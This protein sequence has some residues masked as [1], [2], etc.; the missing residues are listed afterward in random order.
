MAILFVLGSCLFYLHVDG[1]VLR[2][3]EEGLFRVQVEEV[4][5]VELHTEGDIVH[6]IF[7]PSREARSRKETMEIEAWALALAV[8]TVKLG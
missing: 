4:G 7:W 2:D 6:W 1:F 8:C 3:G 5:V